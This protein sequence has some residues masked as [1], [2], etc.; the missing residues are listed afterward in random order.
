[1]SFPSLLLVFGQFGSIAVLLFGGNWLL[2]LWAWALF[3]LGLVIF[4]FAVA[5]LGGSNFTI[6]PD[7]GVGNSLSKRGIYRILRHP[8]YTAVLLCGAAVS[9]GA[10]SPWRWAALAACTVVLVVKVHYEERLLTNVH[11]EYPKLMKGV[12]RLIPW[13]W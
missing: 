11:P 7:P 9:F 10:P 13:V 6:M 4:F 2:P 1:M 3:V 12:G 8:M 5:S